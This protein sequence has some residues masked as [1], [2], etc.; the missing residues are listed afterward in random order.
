MPRNG[1]KD[2]LA[3]WRVVPK[4]A[5]KRSASPAGPRWCPLQHLKEPTFVFVSRPEPFFM[6]RSG[7]YTRPLHNYPQRLRTRR[8]LRLHVCC[9]FTVPKDNETSVD[10][11][12]TEKNTNV[13]R[14]PF[15]SIG[16]KGLHSFLYCI[17]F[18]TNLS[19]SLFSIVW[20]RL[21]GGSGF[22][23][24][25]CWLERPASKQL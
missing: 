18:D 8:A 25:R 19:G 16:T 7:P 15:C 13:S 21:L 14:T 3:C 11:Q 17:H 2:L 4:F 24:V 22:S 1:Q 5:S 9:N 20:C 10:F 12:R 23:G 6:C